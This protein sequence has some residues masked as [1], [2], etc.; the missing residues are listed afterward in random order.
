MV[1]H[2][3]RYL[4]LHRWP[5]FSHSKGPIL[6]P[7]ILTRNTVCRRPRR[8][9]KMNALFLNMKSSQFQCQK[10]VF[11]SLKFSAGLLSVHQVQVQRTILYSPHP[12]KPMTVN[13]CSENIGKLEQ[14]HKT[15]QRST[16]CVPSTYCNINL[17]P[18]SLHHPSQAYVPVASPEALGQ[19]AAGL[20][21]DR[22]P[23]RRLPNWT[24][25]A[26]QV[27]NWRNGRENW[28]KMFKI[29]SGIGLVKTNKVETWEDWSTLRMETHPSSGASHASAPK[30]LDMY[31]HTKFFNCI[32]CDYIYI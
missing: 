8:F 27:W 3:W 11:G 18:K 22:D 10:I 20:L 6:E 17:P 2:M 14:K 29:C 24:V 19:P 32:Y 13:C 21:D 31:I 1:G 12:T 5:C 30:T 25:N 7:W 26:S 15:T 4:D 16:R 28:F 9:M 23:R